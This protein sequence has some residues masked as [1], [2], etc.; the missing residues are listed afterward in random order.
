MATEDQ[1]GIRAR[2]AQW[3]VAYEPP[4]EIS[5]F[6]LWAVL[7]RRKW[8]ILAIWVVVTLLAVAYAATTEPQYRY[9]MAIE[10]GTRTGA[11]GDIEPIEPPQAVVAKMENNYIAAAVV[12]Y[13]NQHE[14]VHWKPDVNA[15][16]P[17][18]SGIVLLTAEGPSE[19]RDVYR[20][21]FQ[22]AL[23]RLQ[24]DHKRVTKVEQT[25]LQ[26]QIETARSEVTAA[27]KEI[28]R[29]RGGQDRLDQ[30]EKMLRADIGDLQQQ[31]ASAR[32]ERRKLAGEGG[33]EADTTGL[34][35][36]NSEI[37]ALTDRLSQ[38]QSQLQVDLP[39]RRDDLL[40]QIND[41]QNVVDDRRGKVRTLQMR[42]Q[43]LAPTHALSDIQRS[44][45][46]V[47]TGDAVIVALG[48]ILGLML[49]VFAA[50][51]AEFVSR[52]NAHLHEADADS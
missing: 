40:S 31:L 29:L 41:K 32:S 8:H 38:L 35:M 14:D 12:Q 9:S 28:D 33:T 26:Q 2:D 5:L 50:F 7:V 10:I 48:V 20:A 43:N 15:S 42:L 23:G 30:Q 16:T 19:R 21:L 18:S 11:N 36:V 27:E 49:G 6:D 17:E 25:Q 22:S 3:P 13:L 4:D 46:P 51:F 34:I 1:G 47:G 45:S 52:A 37:R 24:D 39:A 44:L